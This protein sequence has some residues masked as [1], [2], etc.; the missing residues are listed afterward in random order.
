[1]KNLELKEINGG[2]E[3]V[4]SQKRIITGYLSQVDVEDDGKDII[5][6]GAFTKTLSE[7]RDK[8]VFL[9]QHKWEQPHG[10]FSELYVD[11]Y[12]LKFTSEKLPDTSYSNDVLKLIDAKIINTASI[13]YYATKANNVRGNRIIKEL[14]LME[15]STVT[16][17]MNSG[18][19]ITGLKSLNIKEVELKEKAIL[20]AFRNGT[21]TD[22]TF[23]LLE[24]ALKELQMQSYELGKK[25]AL[26]E[27]TEVT[28]PEPQ[29]AEILKHLK[30]F[31]L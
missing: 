24:L 26:L 28:Q 30:N 23:T 8:I 13:G 19:I 2:Y 21:F 11:N 1:M 9:N 4:D 5:E 15:G 14:I 6:K 18:A 7:R 16:M 27:P 12:G 31:K 20:K 10:K 25:D 22:E 29:N 17:G 3:D